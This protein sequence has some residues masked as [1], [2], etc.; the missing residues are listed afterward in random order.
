MYAARRGREGVVR[1]LLNHGCDASA[2]D[3]VSNVESLAPAPILIDNIR[4]LSWLEWRDRN[5]GGSV[6]RS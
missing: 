2:V 6:G 4:H 3:K 5:Y 1:I